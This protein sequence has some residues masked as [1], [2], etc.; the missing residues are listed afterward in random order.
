V[1]DWCFEKRLEKIFE[2]FNEMTY[3]AT[4]YTYSQH[5]VHRYTD[6]AL[7]RSK[8]EMIYFLYTVYTA[9]AISILRNRCF[10]LIRTV[11]RNAIYIRVA[12]LCCRNVILTFIKL[13][14]CVQRHRKTRSEIPERYKRM[15]SRVIA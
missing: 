4:L 3:N 5:D 6:I 9:R 12:L 13:G 10:L 14:T 15:K 11:D 8:N 2:H 1:L 7:S